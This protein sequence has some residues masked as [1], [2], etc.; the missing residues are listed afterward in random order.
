M[1]TAKAVVARRALPVVVLG[2]LVLPVA[3]CGLVPEQFPADPKGTLTRVEGG[4]L[5]VGVSPH[6]PWTELPDGADADPL[7]PTG[8]EADLVA[9]FA[10]EVGAE[11]VW[12]A[13]T[14]EQLLGDL[15]AG[16]L[17]LVVGGFTARTPWVSHAAVTRPYTTVPAETGED[18]PHVMLTP[19]GEN[20]FLVAL[21]RYLLDQ[22]VGG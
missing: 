18:E 10:E 19:M 7:E 16:K 20:A 13:G 6:P 12:E 9:G 3:G 14:E 1:S 5:R 2:A 22:E 17:D 11:V 4:F 8:L 21:E 15:E